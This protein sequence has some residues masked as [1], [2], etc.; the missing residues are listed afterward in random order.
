M[1]GKE[2]FRRLFDYNRWGNRRAVA[3]LST[4]SDTAERPRKFFAHI[5]G[6]ERIWLARID[7]AMPRWAE[8]F[9]TLTLEECLAA[10]DTLHQQWTELLDKLP[11]GRLA[12]DVVYKTTKGVEFKTPLQDVLMHVVMHSAYHRGQVA[13]AVREAGGKPAAT[14][15]VVYAREG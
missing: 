6:A 3:S 1:E 5:V 15:Y 9:P 13:S 4:V 10:V 2:L 12:E 14:D 8:P 11:V 7:S